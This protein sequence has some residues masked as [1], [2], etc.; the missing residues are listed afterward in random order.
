[1]TTHPPVR[2][3]GGTIADRKARLLDW[4]RFGICPCFQQVVVDRLAVKRYEAKRKAG[5]VA[6]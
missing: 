1:M 3:K 6:A 5:K 2:D 4:K